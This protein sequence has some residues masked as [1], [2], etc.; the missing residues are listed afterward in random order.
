MH[1]Q[2]EAI[3]RMLHNYHIIV[4]K[5]GGMARENRKFCRQKWLHKQ[6]SKHVQMGPW[7]APAKIPVLF[8]RQLEWWSLTSIFLIFTLLYV[9]FST[10]R[11][12]CLIMS[13]QRPSKTG[14]F[15][16]DWM[17]GYSHRSFNQVFCS[18]LSNKTG[19]IIF[20]FFNYI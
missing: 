13:L 10:S 5:K 11:I 6:P 2:T 15:W 20:D 17:C 4:T 12:Q 19:L 16:F 9:K 1:C 18:I 14:I 8:Y 3:S 7:R